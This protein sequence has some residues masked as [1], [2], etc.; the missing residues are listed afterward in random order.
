MGVH[1][2][3]VAVS[4]QALPGPHGFP[5]GL[6]QNSVLVVVIGAAVGVVVGFLVTGALVGALDGFV[7]T[8]ATGAA[9]IVGDVAESEVRG[10][11]SI[12]HRH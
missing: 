9:I 3:P 10:V 2:I 12:T 5:Y 7:A 1:E 4:V 6:L 8:G 11:D